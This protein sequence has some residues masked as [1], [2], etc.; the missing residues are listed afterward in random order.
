MLALFCLLQNGI[1]EN[2]VHKQ[3]KRNSIAIDIFDYNIKFEF[4]KVQNQ[5]DAV[6]IVTVDKYSTVF[7]GKVINV[8]ARTTKHRFPTIESV[9][10]PLKIKNENYGECIWG[11]QLNK[12]SLMTLSEALGKTISICSVN[13]VIQL[14]SLD[15]QWDNCIQFEVNA[16]VMQSI[17]LKLAE[18]KRRENW[19][20]GF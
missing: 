8:A 18:Q 12:E 11:N 19:Q 10:F 6:A 17:E 1:Y 15:K 5:L 9:K 4:S 13:G 20:S 7:H 3:V 2:I 14:Y 16:N